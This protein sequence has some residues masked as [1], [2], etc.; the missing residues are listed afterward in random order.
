LP[1]SRAQADG[2]LRWHKTTLDGRIAVYGD[3]GDGPPVVFV[4]GWALSAR[5]YA[6]S[7]PMI[8]AHGHRVIAPALPGFGRSDELPGEYTFEKMANWLDDLLDHLGIDEPAALERWHGGSRTPER[9]RR[10][11]PTRPRG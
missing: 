7:L 9:R 6:R 1:R 11:Q 5:A 2:D 10:S 8:A 3:A 4:H